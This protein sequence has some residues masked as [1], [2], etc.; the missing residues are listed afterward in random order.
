MLERTPQLAVG[1]DPRVRAHRR[2]GVA[3]IAQQGRKQ[4]GGRVATGERHLAGMRVGLEGAE[5][6]RMV[7]A[8]AHQLRHGR[9][10]R[11]R[12]R[13]VANELHAVRGQSVERRRRRPRVA[14]RAQAIGARGVEQNEDDRRRCCAGPRAAAPEHQQRQQ[15]A[16]EH[17]AR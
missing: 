9:T 6:V 8:A 2:G 16:P 13:E 14:P 7:V 5:D 10:R 17:M 11:V 1:G 12:V 15:G 3:T 4:R